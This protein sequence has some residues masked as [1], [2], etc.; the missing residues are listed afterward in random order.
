MPTTDATPVTVR[1]PTP[2]RSATDG[3]ST[4]EV[5]AA[6]VDEGLR[7][8][9]DRYP[10]LVDNLYDKDDELR[11]FVNIYVGDEDV[12]FGDGVDTA[13]EPGDEVSIVPS[14]AGG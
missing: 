8:L 14:I 7:T 1:I 13:L 11:Q 12:R 4:V 9:V 2:L 6:T 10:D 3:Q 5:E